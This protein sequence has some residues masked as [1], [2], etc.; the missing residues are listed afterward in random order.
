MGIDTMGL[1]NTASKKSPAIIPAW[2]EVLLRR[3][4][5]RHGVKSVPDACVQELAKQ[6]I[7]EAE[8]KTIMEGSRQKPTT[9]D[10]VQEIEVTA[11]AVAVLL[12]ANDKL[13]RKIVE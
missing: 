5:R 8:L 2:V 4:L 7:S 10:I 1:L 12:N 3:K 11:K 6:S 13:D 9:S